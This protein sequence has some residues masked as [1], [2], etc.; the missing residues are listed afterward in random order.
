MRLSVADIDLCG[1]RVRLFKKLYEEK[2]RIALEVV[3]GCNLLIFFITGNVLHEI[4][5]I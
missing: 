1:S 3:C 2:K 4:I 5:F